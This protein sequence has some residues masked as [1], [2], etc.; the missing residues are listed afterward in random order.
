MKIS[1]LSLNIVEMD[2]IVQ[3]MEVAEAECQAP[4][5]FGGVVGVVIACCVL[6]LLWSIV[7]IL[8]VNKINVEQG[9]DGE[10]DSL[11]GDIPESQ[12]KLIV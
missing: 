10:S 11:V 12:K 8:S 9:I 2:A 6:G 7:N 4:L 5:P 3:T 1:T